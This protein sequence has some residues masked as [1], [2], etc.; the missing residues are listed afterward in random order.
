MQK[1]KHLFFDLDHTIWDFATNEKVTLNHLFIKYKLERFFVSFDDFF[2]R[3]NPIN[4]GLWNQY[5]NGE[6]RKHDLNIGRFYNTFLTVGY[7]DKAEAESFAADFVKTNP[8]QTAL[9]PHTLALLNYLKPR[10]DMHIITNG[11]I[12]TQHVKIEKSGLKPF[13]NKVFISEE[14]G[15]QKPKKAFF[16]YAI[17]SCNARKKESLIIGDSLE[18]DIQGAKNFGLDHVYFNPLQTPHQEKLFKEITSLTELQGW[19]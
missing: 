3:Y 11:F 4:I 18:A 10:Y 12:E 1:Y 6:I 15:H 8:T 9:I 19:L 14:I 13:F 2:H 17:K 7:N 5:R 16:E